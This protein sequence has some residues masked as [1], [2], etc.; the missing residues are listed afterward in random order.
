MHT[1]PHPLPDEAAHQPGHSSR[2]E[3]VRLLLYRLD[4][5]LRGVDEELVVAVDQELHRVHCW[6]EHP[7]AGKGELLVLEQ[8]LVHGLL[9]D[10]VEEEE[11]ADGRRAQ[12]DPPLRR[13]PECPVLVPEQGRRRVA[14]GHRVPDGLVD[15]GAAVEHVRVAEVRRVVLRE[16]P[17]EVPPEP[18]EV[19]DGEV[20]A[21]ACVQCRE[22]LLQEGRLDDVVGVERKDPL[23]ARKADAKVARVRKAPVLLQHQPHAV[24]LLAVTRHEAAGHLVA[25]VRRPVVDDDDLPVPERLSDDAVDG[26]PEDIGLVVERDDDGDLRPPVRNH[27]L[28]PRPLLPA[29]RRCQMPGA[30]KAAVGD[31]VQPHGRLAVGCVAPIVDSEG[32]GSARGLERVAIPLEGLGRPEQHLLRGVHDLRRHAGDG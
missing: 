14:A 12:P 5:L 20:R 30:A 19:C 10:T 24:A 8:G 22:S 9:P 16:D 31:D 13:Y 7:H 17:L 26:L 18:L 15:H 23:R 27:V 32:E 28:D 29:A 1:E 21:G 4:D 3:F 2:R 11:L 6:V 25:I